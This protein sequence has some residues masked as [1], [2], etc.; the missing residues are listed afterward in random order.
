[1]S[2]KKF[3]LKGKGG[4]LTVFDDKVIIEVKGV[5]GFLTQGLAGG[6]TIPMEAIQSVQFRKGGAF[7]N[8]FIQFGIM[9][10]REKQGGVLAA[11]DDE[12]SVVFS[13][14]QND[15]AEEI[16]NYIEGIILNRSKGGQTVVQQAS[17]ADEILKFKN[18]LDAGV[19]TQE[20]FDA[21]KKAL[22]GL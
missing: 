5:L 8:G 18:L 22:L 4:L 15:K 7:V 19:I 14:D 20:E 2:E 6:K 12:N 11:V 17:A 10:G 21:K 16:K 9:G 1:M 13:M 3:E